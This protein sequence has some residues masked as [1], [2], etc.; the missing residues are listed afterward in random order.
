[1]AIKTWSDRLEEA[2]HFSSE[3]YENDKVGF[4]ASEIEELRAELGRVQAIEAASIKTAPACL[5]TNDK[6]MWVLGWDE[7][8]AVVLNVEEK[9]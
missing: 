9:V 7:C 3:D 4:M 2:A 6:A 5:N 1:M 8:R